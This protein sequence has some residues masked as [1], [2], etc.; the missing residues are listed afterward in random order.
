MV[1]IPS[2]PKET[3]KI[4]PV[5]DFME[6]KTEAGPGAGQEREPAAPGS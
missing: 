1:M 4:L 5:E 6:K 3:R 2:L